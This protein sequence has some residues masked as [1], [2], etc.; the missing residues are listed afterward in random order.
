MASGRWW[1]HLCSTAEETEAPI[2][3]L[4]RHAAGW[5]GVVFPTCV[6][7]LGKEGFLDE[8]FLLVLKSEWVVL[9]CV[10]VCMHL[11]GIPGKPGYRP[12]SEF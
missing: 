11:G 9:K 4:P 1:C 10:C 3:S 2:S 12:R 8:E 7:F 5:V 6:G